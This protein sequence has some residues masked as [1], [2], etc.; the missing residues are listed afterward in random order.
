MEWG[1]IEVGRREVLV[2]WHE[3]LDRFEDGFEWDLKELVRVGTF[4]CKTV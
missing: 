1:G 2:D 4:Y 3:D